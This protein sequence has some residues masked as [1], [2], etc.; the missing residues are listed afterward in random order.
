MQCIS[1]SLHL[2][3]HPADFKS[4]FLTGGYLLC[5]QMKDYCTD[6]QA[7]RHSLLLD[8]FG[9]RLR[10]RCGHA[11]NNCLARH[12]RDQADSVWQVQTLKFT[13]AKLALQQ[14]A[15]GASPLGLRKGHVTYGL[16]SE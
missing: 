11:C 14:L 8:Y 6:D 10:G 12:S 7:C 2:H 1:S 4:G 3:S 16:M 15:V 5:A 9:E 13:S